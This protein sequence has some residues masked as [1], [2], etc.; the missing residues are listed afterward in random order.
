VS[1][2]GQWYTTDAIGAASQST[3]SSP[4]A[5]PAPDEAHPL[6]KDWEM[7]NHWLKFEDERMGQDLELARPSSWGDTPAVAPGGD[8]ELAAVLY[9]L[10]CEVEDA[11]FFEKNRATRM[12]MEK[13]SHLAPSD[14]MKQ[15]VKEM[16]PAPR[17]RINT[18][19]T[20]ASSGYNPFDTNQSMSDS[21]QTIRPGPS[22]PSPKTSPSASPQI[23]QEYFDASRWSH[24]PATS[25]MSHNVAR[26]SV[27]TTRSSLSIPPDAHFSPSLGLGISTAHTTPENA[28]SSTMRRMLSTSSLVPIAL[29]DSAMGWT[30]VCRKVQVE[31]KSVR[32]GNG[33]E[34]AVFEK[35]ECDVFWSHRADGG[36]SLCSSYRPEGRGKAKTWIL[37]DFP[38]LGPS[39]PLTTTIDGEICIDFP[40]GSFGKLNKQMTDVIYTFG[41]S[42]S[43]AVFQTLLYTNNGK[44]AAELLFDRPMKTIS[45]DKHRPECRSKN[46]RLWRR[47]VMHLDS[48]EP[49]SVDVVMLLFYTSCLEEKG[50]WVEEPHYA[51]EWL[52][53]SVYK[54]DSDKLTLAFSKDAARWTSDKLYPGR[55]G[56]TS[57]E[58]PTS[59]T[60]TS[61]R[62]DSM[63]IPAIRRSGTGISTSS[64][65]A[66][67]LSTR[68]F[69]GRSK[70]SSSTGNTNACGY[71]K[72]DLE[73]QNSKD[74]RAF[75]D[76]WK[77]YVRP[78][79]S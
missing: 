69:F 19:D 73:F 28:L 56:S 63:E 59:P 44:D 52:T 31:R 17:Q 24:S 32:S 71:S 23:E 39:I 48:D 49:V 40:R 41:N 34:K 13:R 37:Q 14:A 11:I 7:F 10:R 67:I 54:K 20:N 68:S 18:L 3:P 6:Y 47:S 4:L 53:E 2:A 60:N 15:Q 51:F 27:S 46:L 16:P 21:M 26:S 79:G 33:K 77:K 62:K 22:T 78:L 42:D 72:L 25:S 70:R 65:A 8:P 1:L 75:L 5:L 29:G 38:P 45:S 64:A 9:R 30:L 36:M 61:K 58:V 55:K 43:A 76:V 35:Q 66:S 50:H 57:S 74:R 12:A